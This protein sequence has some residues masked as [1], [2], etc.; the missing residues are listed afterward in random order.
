MVKRANWEPY[1]P[2]WLIDLAREQH[3]EEAWLPEALAACTRCRRESEAYI[4]FVDSNRPNKP[5]SGWQFDTNLELQSPTEGWIVLD[6]LVD[7][8]VGGVEFV[9]KIKV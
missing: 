4:H 6:I 2:T 3:P 8:R 1:D 7:H 5:G 9:D